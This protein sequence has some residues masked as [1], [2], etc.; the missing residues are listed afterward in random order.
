MAANYNTEA[1]LSERLLREAEWKRQGHVYP[2][3]PAWHSE[4][5]GLLGFI[6]AHGRVDSYWPDLTSARPRQFF[7]ALQ[8]IRVARFLAAN[9][10]PVAKWQPPGRGNHKGEFSVQAVP[11][12]IFVEVKSPD[13]EGQLTPEERDAGR[14]EQGKYSNLV[15]GADD[16]WR[17]IRASVKKAYP[18]FS[19]VQPNLLV[20]AD[21]RWLPLVFSGE[22]SVQ[23]ALH[24][25]STVLDGEAGYFTT[26]NFENLGGVALFQAILPVDLPP[27]FSDKPLCY[28]FLLY[29]NPKAR[30][31]TALPANFIQTFLQA[32]VANADTPL[33]T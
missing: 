26:T 1:L 5:E 15:H 19:L 12:P 3:L 6:Q 28:E 9:G 25:A 4:L 29:P 11:L 8:E 24:F 10:F 21:D 22:L 2:T 32:K 31:E 18:K 13:W 17:A 23:H 16:G 33:S 27:E 20:I 7:A 14:K 30:A